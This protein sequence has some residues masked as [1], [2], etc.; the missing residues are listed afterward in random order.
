MP[1]RQTSRSKVPGAEAFLPAL[2]TLPALRSAV[3]NCQ[4]C[5]LYRNATQAVFGEADAAPATRIRMMMV[6]EQ[7]GDREDKEGHPFVGPAG[8]FLDRC[9]EEAGIDRAQV[10]VTNAVKHFK[11]EPRGK[12]RLHKKPSSSEIFACS[13]WLHAEI[14]AVHPELIVCLGATAS[15]SLLGAAFRVTRA[16]GIIQQLE[17]WPPILATAHPASILRART[18]EDRHRQ[19]AEFVADLR[20]ARHFLDGSKKSS[21]RKKESR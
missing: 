13:P 10:Y 17:G 12:T 4:G 2:P 19:A 21:P 20:A 1:T 16:H 9:L 5:D 3:Q 7:P 18:D 8:K 14:E 11:W 6:G 15:Q